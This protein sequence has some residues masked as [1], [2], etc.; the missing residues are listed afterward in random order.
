MAAE[1]DLQDVDV[2][3]DEQQEPAS[4][5]PEE[6][7]VDETAGQE[8][9]EVDNA[10]K[11]EEKTDDVDYADDENVKA[12]SNANAAKKDKSPINLIRPQRT[13]SPREIKIPSTEERKGRVQKHTVYIIECDPSPPGVVTV[14]RRY[15]DFK[16]LRQVLCD[17][18]PG[19]FVPPLPP[20]NVIGRFEDS[21]IEERRQDLAR[22]LNRIEEVKPFAECMAFG[23]FLSRPETTFVEGRKEVEEQYSSRS[24]EETAMMLCKLF[25]DL[26]E[27]ELADDAHETD[28]QE[29]ANYLTKVDEQMSVLDKSAQRLFKH[30][31]FVSKEM[32]SFTEAFD[33]LYSAESNYPY[34]ATAERLDVRDQFK[35]WSSFQTKQTDCYYDNFFRALRY[36]QEDVKA[37]LELF[38]YH[39]DLYTKRYQKVCKSIE[40]WQ[41]METNGVELKP[42][43]QRQKENDF[44]TRKH[45]KLLLDIV[46][47]IILRNEIVLIWNNKTAAFRDRI[48][49]FT[50]LQTQITNKMLLNWKNVAVADSGNNDQQQV[51]GNQDNDD[52]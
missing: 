14:A 46:T 48:Q 52:D 27:E 39:N 51:D 20:A 2:G 5:A 31:N 24:D 42:D 6:D 25:P 1:S 4:N 38:K 10:N 28:V 26:D 18:Y 40:K 47:K 19:L 8:V 7:N 32:S 44:E 21:F 41:E 43:K 22:F 30:L 23:M 15:N 29:L 16:W 13:A 49:A 45:I 50:K 33:G 36:E 17:Q 34:K 12:D 37:L 9:I 35:L 3:D 11:Q